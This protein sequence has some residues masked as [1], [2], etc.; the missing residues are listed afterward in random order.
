MEN[1]DTF[2]VYLI[3]GDF[4]DDFSPLVRLS[5]LSWSDAHRLL[6]IV[7]RNKNGDLGVVVQ[8]EHVA[9]DAQ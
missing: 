3:G 7:N 1:E 8:R 4:A 6:K 2:T 9:G 5:A